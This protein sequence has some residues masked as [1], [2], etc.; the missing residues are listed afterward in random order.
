MAEHAWKK[1][2]RDRVGLGSFLP[3]ARQEPGPAFDGPGRHRLEAGVGS[4]F[5]HVRVHGGRA[6]AQ[7]A[8]RLGARAFTIGQDVYLGAEAHRL[9]E[10]ARNRLLVHEAVHTAQQGAQPSLPNSLPVSAPGDASEREAHAIADAVVPDSSPSLRLR[11]EIRPGGLAM[12]RLARPVIQRDLAAT[13]PVTEGEFGVDLKT[14]SHAGAKS[15]MSGTIKFIANTKAPDSHLIKLLQVVRD[16]DIDTG[17][18]YVWTGAEAN[19]NKMMTSA[20]PT[21][22]V[23]E[24][25]FVD[26]R[27]EATTPRKAKSD[28]EISPYYRTYWKNSSSSQDGSKKGETVKEASLWDSPGSAGKRKFRFETAAKSVDSGH[29][30]GTVKWG[31][32]LTDPAKGTVSNEFANV[33]DVQSATF[34]AA[35]RSFDEF[36]RNSGSSTAPKK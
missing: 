11:H 36:Y 32:D 8:E 13:Y 23:T 12:S 2:A 14:E 25:F 3:A 5:S 31:F 18:D 9:T 26:H 20:A 7:A 15:G 17:K 19:R 21:T 28:D 33:H 10:V 1:P 29:I 35:V 6:S 30:Y 27:A 24:G 22:G 16:I 34:D 4:D